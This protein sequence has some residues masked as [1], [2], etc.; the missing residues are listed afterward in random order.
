M[1]QRRQYA[2]VV[3]TYMYLYGLRGMDTVPV[4]HVFNDGIRCHL[5][6][7]GLRSWPSQALVFFFL[8]PSKGSSLQAAA[9]AAA[10]RI[11]DDEMT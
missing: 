5:K 3:Y 10:T 6:Y 9:A 2:L 4:P 7:R 1:I 8:I 11:P